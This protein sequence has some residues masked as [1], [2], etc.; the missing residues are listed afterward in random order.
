MLPI[1]SKPPK[2]FFGSKFKGSPR[3]KDSK[4]I[5]IQL[6]VIRER[7]ENLTSETHG[8]LCTP[9]SRINLSASQKGET[10]DILAETDAQKPK[11]PVLLIKD[12]LLVSESLKRSPSPEI[13]TAAY[14]DQD[15]DPSS[16]A[17]PGPQARARDPQRDEFGTVVD[18]AASI[19]ESIHK[20]MAGDSA[21]HASQIMIEARGSGGPS[22]AVLRSQ[23][24][25]K[26][27]GGEVDRSTFSKANKSQ[28]QEGA[29][30]DL[31]AAEKALPPS[32]A[33]DVRLRTLEG[34][35]AAQQNS[36]DGG[37]DIGIMNSAQ[38]MGLISFSN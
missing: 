32:G 31:R 5:V 28:D 1:T 8:K 37:S 9:N 4:D 16:Q 26:L 3:V 35:H 36:S 27:S 29:A 20:S 14:A 7:Q 18:G 12:G 23:E 34:I 6:E 11:Q 10:E 15:Q 22:P 38:E 21:M 25:S 19:T 33:D 24:A 30:V 13:H 17:S 2:R